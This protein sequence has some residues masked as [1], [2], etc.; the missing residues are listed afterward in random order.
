MAGRGPRAV[1]A[2]AYALAME[3]ETMIGW[4][5]LVNPCRLAQLLERLEGERARSRT[6]RL[7]S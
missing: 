7:R 5:F 1:A 2:G 6:L 3:F 4:L